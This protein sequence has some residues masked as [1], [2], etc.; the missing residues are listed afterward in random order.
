MKEKFKATSPTKIDAKI[1]MENRKPTLAIHT[2]DA[3]KLY[4]HRYI[5]CYQYINFN[6]FSFLKICIH[7]F[8]TLCR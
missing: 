1:L 8:G 5:F 3:Q 4:T 6:S 7:Y 2:R